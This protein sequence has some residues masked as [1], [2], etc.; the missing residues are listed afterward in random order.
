MFFSGFDIPFSYCKQSQVMTS[1]D[2]SDE[3]HS[4]IIVVSGTGRENEGGN[5]LEEVI[6]N[7][8]LPQI[9]KQFIT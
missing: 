5:Q 4:T 2:S 3:V 8:K 6:K 9:T 7:V 1:D